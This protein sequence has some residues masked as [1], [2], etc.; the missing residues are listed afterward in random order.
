MRTIICGDRN[1]DNK[2]YL[3]FV[4]TGLDAMHGIDTVISGHARGADTMGE[5][6]ARENNKELL[7]FPAEWDKYQQAGRK[8]PAGPIRNRQMLKEGKP[9]M[10]VA[11]HESLATSKGTKD[12]VKIAKQSGVLTYVFPNQVV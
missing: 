6:W 8:N 9:D 2:E 3:F 12:M 5:L 11:F 7:I 10:V 1:W 4:L